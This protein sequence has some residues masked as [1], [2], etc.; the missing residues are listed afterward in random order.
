[1][2]ATGKTLPQLLE[3]LSQRSGLAGLSG[4]GGDMRDIEAAINAG[5]ERAKLA[6]EVF[7]QAVRHYLG[8][9]LLHLGGAD[10]VVFTGGIGVNSPAVRAAVCANL[11]WFRIALDPPFNTSARAEARI[12]AMGSQVQVWVV[13]TNEELILARQAK[14]FLAPL[15][16]EWGR[17]VAD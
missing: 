11:D 2:R 15:E 13:P 6:F 16:G 14:T 10:A 17:L 1:M 8:A 4:V 7:V 12:D 3:D 9:A 5:N